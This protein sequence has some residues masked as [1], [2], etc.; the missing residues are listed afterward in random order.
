[1]PTRSEE[2]RAWNRK[3][4]A[5]SYAAAA[6]AIGFVLFVWSP[7]YT[8]EPMEEQ[9]EIQRED[10]TAGAVVPVFVQV[11]FG[12]PT[13]VRPDGTA[14]TTEPPTRVLE[15]GSV[16][17]LPPECLGEV[18]LASSE[19]SGSLRLRVNV[20]GEA[21][22]MEIVEESA[23]ACGN[24]LMTATAGA[25]RYHWLPS[26]AFPAPVELVQPVLVVDIAEVL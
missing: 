17:E 13:I 4:F 7:E 5:W 10:Q 15:T 23:S 1:M 21:T 19:L 16:V 20:A 26:E 6:L 12:P 8:V 25:L 11:L 2:L 18:L 14:S 9:S 3:V 24:R 22:V